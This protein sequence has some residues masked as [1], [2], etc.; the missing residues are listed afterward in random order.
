MTDREKLLAFLNGNAKL[1]SI[2]DILQ[3]YLYS[4]YGDIS[5]LQL[6]QMMRDVNDVIG[7]KVRGLNRAKY[8][9]KERAMY[10]KSYLSGEMWLT[11]EAAKANVQPQIDNAQA[12]ID[13]YDDV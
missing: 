2:E 6:N 4:F 3:V 10:L 1:N 13:A 7:Q 9:A 5:V 12:I 11:E 8:I